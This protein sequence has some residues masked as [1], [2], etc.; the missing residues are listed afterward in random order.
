VNLASTWSKKDIS[1]GGGGGKG[2]KE[3]GVAYRYS[4]KNANLS[5]F[6]R[7]NEER[8]LYQAHQAMNRRLQENVVP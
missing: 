4:F 8:S 5:F 7:Q 1:A 2:R 6:E 3:R